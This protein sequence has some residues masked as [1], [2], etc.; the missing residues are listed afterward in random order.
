MKKER[1]I[2]LLLLHRRFDLLVVHSFY[3][4]F[5]G[6]YV[7]IHELV[8]SSL[9]RLLQVPLS[10]INQFL[11]SRQPLSLVFFV[12]YCIIIAPL[13]APQPSQPHNLPS[14]HPS[15][16]DQ[17]TQSSFHPLREQSSH[18]GSTNQSSCQRKYCL[19][20]RS[21]LF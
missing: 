9:L 15:R 19:T 5:N 1:G 8:F 11:K 20:V 21:I 2:R 14:I 17:V 10:L 4:E 3:S 13:D 12:L 16:N 18:T 6:L 7:S